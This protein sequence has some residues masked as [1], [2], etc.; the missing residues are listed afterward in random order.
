M[1]YTTATTDYVARP[2]IVGGNASTILTPLS[3]NT[4][5]NSVTFSPSTI[6]IAAGQ[7]QN[8]TITLSTLPTSDVGFGFTTTNTSSGISLS[9][10]S[11]A[12]VN[13]TSSDTL[14]K[15][16]LICAA[17]NATSGSEIY[18][19]GVSGTNAADFSTPSSL[20][21][22]V[23]NSTTVV[24]DITLP[25]VINVPRGGCSTTTSLVATQAPVSDVSLTF[26]GAIINSSSL[27]INNAT[28]NAVTFLPTALTQSFTICAATNATNAVI[29][30][31]ITGTD[32][33]S[34]TVNGAQTTNLT[35]NV[36]SANSTTGPFQIFAPTFAGTTGTASLASTSNGTVYYTISQT[37]ATGTAPLTLDQVMNYVKNSTGQTSV[38]GPLDFLT[39]SY[40]NPRY[41]V[42]GS[43][44]VSTA[45][46]TPIPLVDI[47]PNTTYSF[48]GYFKNTTAQAA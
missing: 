38:Q 48:C 30:V 33:S 18:T 23:T 14:S 15:T 41:L 47:E 11:N 20:S 40:A 2:I 42:V 17:S 19:V 27:T 26:A 29:P 8:V 16:L 3:V 22:V 35:V 13:F 37:N 10:A 21:V 31:T 34:F 44:T 4:V 6:S 45:S 28:T 39:Y 43:S 36:V 25:T 1:V 7:C 24:K 46:S 9:G 12:V 32:S 5:V